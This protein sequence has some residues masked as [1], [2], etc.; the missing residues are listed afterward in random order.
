MFEPN[1]QYVSP[2][3]TL[4]SA[5]DTAGVPY[6]PAPFYDGRRMTFPW[7]PRADVVCHHYSAAS[8]RGWVETLGFPWDRN[9]VTGLAPR[10]AARRIV[11]CYRRLNPDANAAA[12][13]AVQ[14]TQ[15]TEQTE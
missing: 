2:M 1:D 5:L 10:V 6:T 4:G 11:R 8:E 14:Q 7:F 15:Q 13:T 12:R 9:G 3:I